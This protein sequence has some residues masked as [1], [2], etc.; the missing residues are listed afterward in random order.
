MG[1][2]DPAG[3]CSAGRRHRDRDEPQRGAPVELLLD[4]DDGRARGGALLQG[5]ISALEPGVDQDR[6]EHLVAA[7][8]EPVE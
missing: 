7:P 2:L 4:P 6:I 5:A 3:A 8:V 1:D